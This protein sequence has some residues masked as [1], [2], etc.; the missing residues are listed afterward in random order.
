MYQSNTAVPQNNDIRHC[1]CKQ[2]IMLYFL[3]AIN[4][5]KVLRLCPTTS[6]TFYGGSDALQSLEFLIFCPSLMNQKRN[7][8]N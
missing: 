1:L 3:I 8:L 7:A 6:A 5:R 4:L 2:V